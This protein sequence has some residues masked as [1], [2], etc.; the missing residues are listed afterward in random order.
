MLERSDVLQRQLDTY[1][2]DAPGSVAV[3]ADN[4]SQMIVASTHRFMAMVAIAQH[5]GYLETPTGQ[6]W[7][8]SRGWNAES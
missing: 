2:D 1:S 8:E 3:G 6:V 4:G 5:F 7:T